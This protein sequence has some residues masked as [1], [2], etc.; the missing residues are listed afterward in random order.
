MKIELVFDDAPPPGLRQGGVFRF[1]P[2]IGESGK[3]AAYRVIDEKGAIIATIPA[4]AVRAWRKSRPSA[5]QS[6]GTNTQILQR[7]SLDRRR[8]RGRKANR[9]SDSP[10][11]R[12]AAL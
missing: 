1:D 2:V 3:V 8:I 12:R 5:K 7:S 6:M 10:R 11:A 4:T 9:G